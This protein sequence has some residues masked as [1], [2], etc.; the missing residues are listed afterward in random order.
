MLAEFMSLNIFGFFLIFSRVGTALMLM[1]GFSATYVNVQI[2][3]ALALAIC[4]VVSATIMPIIPIMPAS[5]GDIF[6]LVIAEVFIGVFLGGIARI[7]LSALQF[8]GTLM[9]M[10]SS[11]A[12]A[13][14]TD[15]VAEQQSSVVSSF[16]TALGIMLIF[17]TDMHHLMIIAVI[18]SYS[19]F[20]PGASLSFGDFAMTVA[21]HTADSFALGLQMASPLVVVALGYNVGLGVLGRLMP[22]LPL[23]FFMMPIQIALQFWILMMSLSAVMMVFLQHYQDTFQMFLVP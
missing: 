6:L 18:E 1:P 15:P 13:L 9:A 7:A 5:I 12:N 10:L 23:F 3:L 14:T 16:L 11:L 2:R 19:L 20:L 4:F 22:A 8:A 21:R 17:I